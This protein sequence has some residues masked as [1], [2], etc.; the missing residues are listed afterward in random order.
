MMP[1]L[2]EVN[3]EQKRVSLKTGQP[4]KTKTGL[5]ILE[6]NNWLGNGHKEAQNISHGLTLIHTDFTTVRQLTRDREGIGPVR[7]E[8]F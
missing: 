4:V 2:V 5:R 6:S 3:Y 7:S 8:F 1:N